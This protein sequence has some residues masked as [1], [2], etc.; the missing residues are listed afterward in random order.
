VS[1]GLAELLAAIDAA[2]EVGD[3]EDIDLDD[4]PDE[5]LVSASTSCCVLP[6]LLSGLVSNNKAT[7]HD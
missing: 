6:Y 1:T 7:L 3:A 2:A 4:C 5:F